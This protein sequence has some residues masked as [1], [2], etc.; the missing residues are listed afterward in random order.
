MTRKEVELSLA[1][2]KDIPRIVSFLSKPEIDRAFVPHLSQR[3]LSIEERVESKLVKGFWLIAYHN[4]VIVGCRGCNGIVDQIKGV[5]EFSTIAVAQN[6][7]RTGI[8]VLLLRTAVKI[9]L[10]RYAPSVM[11]FDSWSTNTTIE[12]MALKVGFIKNRTFEDPAKRPPGIQ[13]VEYILDC[14]KHIREQ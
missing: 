3:S 4:K 13:S 2:K 6:L 12:R 14:S 7:Q 11:K 1:T 8:G 10:E 9:A 5:V